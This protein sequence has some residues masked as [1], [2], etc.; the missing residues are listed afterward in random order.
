[1]K[2][3]KI[4]IFGGS[5]QIGT[6][7]VKKLGKKFKTISPTHAELD[8][9]DRN[10]VE[11]YILAT[12]PNQILYIA[13]YTNTDGAREEAGKAFLLNAGAV[14]HITRLAA[15]L[16]IPF[17]YLSTE[18]VFN[19]KKTNMP[20]TEKDIPDPLLINGKTKV[21]GEL[22]TLNASKSNSVLRLI[23]CYSPFY[24][25][26]MDLARLTAFKL[27]KGEVFT[28]TV[29]Q[30]VNPIYVNHLAEAIS[31][32]LEEGASG[33]FHLGATDYTTPYEF[34]KKVAKALNLD[35]TLIKPV[36]FADFSKTRPELRP[37]DQWLETKKFRKKFGEGILKS[38]DESIADF[39][40][41]YKRLNK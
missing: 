28:A 36:K 34:A 16:N 17:H 10:S 7:A 18:L 26:K 31:R 39:A 6:V 27:K 8:A 41:D 37:K 11:K 15:H 4:L 5:G 21:L 25:R 23:M 38:I 33:I 22:T 13:G 40:R 19:G 1:M 35:E 30:L 14:L 32:I 29:D 3:K 24:E 9:T 12:K 20:Y 2:R